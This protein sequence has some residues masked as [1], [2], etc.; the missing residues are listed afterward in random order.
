M[1]KRGIV[2][3]LLAAMLL[4]LSACVFKKTSVL[5]AEQAEG[6]VLADPEAGCPPAVPVLMPGERI[7]KEAL[8]CFRYY[9][10]ETCTVVSGR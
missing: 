9:G 10:K 6:R 8:A 7:G 4:S 3:L 1:A 2:L 5:P